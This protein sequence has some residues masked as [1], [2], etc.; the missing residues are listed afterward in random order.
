MS[1]ALYVI[2]LLM[3][4]ASIYLIAAGEGFFAWFSAGLN[5]LGITINRKCKKLEEK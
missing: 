2:F 4:A 5:I 1:K 3:L